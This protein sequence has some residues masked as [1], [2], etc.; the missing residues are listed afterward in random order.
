MR[1]K[2][3]GRQGIFDDAGWTLA[4]ARRL[5]PAR[6]RPGARA[7]HFRLLDGQHVRRQRRRSAAVRQRQ[8]RSQPRWPRVNALPAIATE[9]PRDQGPARLRGACS[10]TATARSAIRA[11]STTRRSIDQ[12]SRNCV[13]SNG[14]I[15]VKMGVSGRVLL[16]PKGNETDDRR[17]APLR[18]RARQRRRSSPS[19]TRSRSRSPPPNQSGDFVKV[20]ENVD[21]PLPRRRDDRHLGRLRPAG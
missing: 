16:G 11:S 1:T 19:A 3:G 21:D 6:C 4:A 18:R 10:F 13:V 7:R 20:V 15:T 9:C 5:R 8:R 12:Q 17:A 14:L 2:V